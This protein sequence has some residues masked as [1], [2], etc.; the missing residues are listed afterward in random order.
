MSALEEYLQTQDVKY[1]EGFSAQVPEELDLL[2]RMV[3]KQNI[4]S[5]L[6]IGF[7]AGHSS[8]LFLSANPSCKVVSFDLGNYRYTPMGKKYIDEHFPGR[9]TLIKGNS[10]QT[11]PEYTKDCTERY[12][13]I[14]IDGGHSLEV[15]TED[16]KN[17]KPLAHPNTIVIMDDVVKQKTLR[18]HWNDGPTTAWDNAIQANIV[19]EFG[20][21]CYKKGRGASWGRYRISL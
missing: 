2:R 13:L 3:Q 9:H 5:V 12:D 4:S 11:V 7:H 6:E 16:I 1:I 18:C 17:C 19:D 15:A 8:E 14:F 10:V 21:E 20:Y